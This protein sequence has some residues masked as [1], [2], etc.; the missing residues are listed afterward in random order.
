MVPALSFIS[1]LTWV[2]F[3]LPPQLAHDF[4]TVLNSIRKLLR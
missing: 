1:R 4:I 2:R 3:P